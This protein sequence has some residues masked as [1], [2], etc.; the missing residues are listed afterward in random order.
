[1]K[2]KSEIERERE[3]RM[4][5][6]MCVYVCMSELGEK[7][8]ARTNSDEEKKAVKICQIYS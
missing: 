4:T 5:R 1:M 7:S 2:E 3:N 8:N 6:H